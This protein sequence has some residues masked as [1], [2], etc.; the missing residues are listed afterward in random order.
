MAI[1]FCSACDRLVYTN[2][3]AQQECPVCLGPLAETEEAIRK[4]VIYL[5]SSPADTVMVTDIPAQRS[6]AENEET[7]EGKP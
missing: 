4:R 1:A 2:G 7:K 3:R 6:K 5:E